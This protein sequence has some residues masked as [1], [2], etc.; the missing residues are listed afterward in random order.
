MIRISADHFLVK[1][2][3]RMEAPRIQILLVLCYN[4]VNQPLSHF[5]FEISYRRCIYLLCTNDL[6][7]SVTAAQQ[8]TYTDIRTKAGPHPMIDCPASINFS[9]SKMH[10][11]QVERSLFVR[12]KSSG[13]EVSLWQYKT[14]PALTKHGVFGSVLMTRA[15]WNA[16]R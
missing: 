6:V 16:C 1:W 9:G 10:S 12:S 5:R 4:C 11:A 3:A 14:I 2:Q 15:H 8:K 13:V 7:S